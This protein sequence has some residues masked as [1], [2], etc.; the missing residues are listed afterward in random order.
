MTDRPKHAGQAIT[1]RQLLH[2]CSTTALGAGLAGSLQASKPATEKGSLKVK[3][4]L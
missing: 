3:N 2:A 1:R 4:P